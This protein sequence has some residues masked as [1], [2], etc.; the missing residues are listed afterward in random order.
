MVEDARKNDGRVIPCWTSKAGTIGVDKAQA[1]QV[2][3]GSKARGSPLKDSQENR[4][5]PPPTLGRGKMK[6]LTKTKEGEL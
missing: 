2:G 3:G 1:K 4:S 6:R 5:Q